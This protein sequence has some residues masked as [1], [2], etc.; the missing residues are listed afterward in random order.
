MRNEVSRGGSQ[1][2]PFS[3]A[4]LINVLTPVRSV[5]AGLLLVVACP[6]HAHDPGLSAAELKVGES[7]LA[8]H[9]TFARRDMEAI[10]AIDADGNG[11]V[12]AA[13]FA[14]ARPQL[15]SL[16]N[17]AIEISA[18][19]QRLSA[20]RAAIEL[21][22]SDALHFRFAFQQ[23]AGSRIGMSVPIIAELA[24]GHRQYLTVRDEDGQILA[25]HLLSPAA[26]QWHFDP[27]RHASRD[28]FRN[29]LAQG[30]WHIWI[31]YDHILF[32]LSLLLPAV[33]RRESARWLPVDRFRVA[34]IE[35][36]KIVTAFTLAHSVTLSLAALG[37]IALPTR[38]VE[39]AIAL[40]VVLAALNNLWP[41][42]DRRRW[43]VA[44]AFGLVHGLGFA[45][46]L[47]DLG[48]PQDS[49]VLALFAFNVGVEAGQLAIIAALL[50]LTYVS[51]DRVSYRRVALGWGSAAIAFVAA[52]WFAERAF[53]LNLPIA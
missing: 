3:F 19:G 10:I 25:D 43:L 37:Y 29:Y 1:P 32:L 11:S 18:D 46:V 23:Q 36:F 9:L 7:G 8:V 22:D 20:K 15:E 41:V 16:A 5:V 13:E 28:S 35:V 52:L 6:A 48:L 24:R 2:R 50:P 40:S 21:D 51:R 47:R 14:A 4:G 12:S 49:L 38:W 34:F 26:W 17:T 45:S 39:S 27:A 31:G 53:D 33:L 30:A 42:I 44:L